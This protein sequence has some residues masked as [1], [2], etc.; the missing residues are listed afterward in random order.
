V[1]W[2]LFAQW[3]EPQQAVNQE[4]DK[5]YGID[6]AEEISLED[7]GL[8]KDKATRGND[9]YRAFWQSEFAS[10][11]KSMEQ[12]AVDFS[13]FTFL[14]Y[15]SGKGK[16]LFLAA[17]FP[18]KS[19]RG[20]E[21]SQ[22]LH[23]IALKNARVYRGERQQCFDIVPLLGDALEYAPPLD[24]LLCFIFNAFD[25]P[26]MKAVLER[27]EASIEATPREVYL[28]YANLRTVT[29]GLAGFRDL[30]MLKPIVTTRTYV[31]FHFTPATPARRALKQTR[32][33]ALVTK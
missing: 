8:P 4:F 5:R 17:D 26:T 6:T 23:E 15:G 13:K 7:A 1:V 33:S 29:E 21:Y 22:I 16:V 12:A 10:I 20:I 2:A 32:P 25:P 24:P 30:R 19:V 27:I 31:I 18:F 14:D 3:L 28:V 11:M 9:F